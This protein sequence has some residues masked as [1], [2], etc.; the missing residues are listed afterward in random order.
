MYDT[1]SKQIDKNDENECIEI[2]KE[3]KDTV[4]KFDL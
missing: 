2:Y 4:L 1:K 3:I